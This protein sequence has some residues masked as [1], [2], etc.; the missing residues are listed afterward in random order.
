[1]TALAETLWIRKGTGLHPRTV[2]G[3]VPL[4]KFDSLEQT[5]IVEH[6]FTTREG[7]VSEGIYS[8][9]NLSFSRGDRK[10]AVF[11]NYRRVA[12]AMHTTP[13][14]IV[15][16]CQTHTTNVE[17]VGSEL[18]GNGIT[19]D[20]AFADVDGR[21]TNEKGVVLATFYADCVPLYFVDPVHRAI[22]LS[23]SGW[24]GTVAKMGRATLD[25]MK[26]AFGTEPKDVVCAIGP[27]ICKDCYEVG[28]EVAEEFAAAFPGQKEQIL[29]SK[30]DGKYLLD[31]WLANKQVL[32]DAGVPENQIEI[33]NLCTC[34]NS[35]Y[36]FSHR[37]LNG[38][39]GNL[40]AFLYLK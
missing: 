14:R 13:D 40:G 24:R 11:E 2:E 23:H 22:G 8:S 26:E 19:R 6:C 36:L 27:C 9:L 21:V 17:R 25:K 12:E 16:S 31:L 3:T 35:R 10:E 7:G 32:M 30:E 37:G 28:T 18:G 33:T 20:N 4:L 1:M 38:K 34:C 5:G 15:C 29:T 39:R